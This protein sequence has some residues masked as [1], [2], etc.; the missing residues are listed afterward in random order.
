M[1]RELN[2]KINKVRSARLLISEIIRNDLSDK[3][4][5]KSLRVIAGS[6]DVC[7]KMMEDEY[8]GR[9]PLQINE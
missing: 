8:N 9:K 2:E 3:K 6:M 1:D 4:W 7:I 5:L